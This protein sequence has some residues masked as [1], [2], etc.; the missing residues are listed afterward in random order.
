MEINNLF[1]RLSSLSLVPVPSSRAQALG[2]GEALNRL[3]RRFRPRELVKVRLVAKIH[4]KTGG[5]LRHHRVEGVLAWLGLS[6][7]QQHTAPV[8]RVVGLVR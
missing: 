4:D 3:F 6:K 1:P 7:L 8:S 2:S 5:E